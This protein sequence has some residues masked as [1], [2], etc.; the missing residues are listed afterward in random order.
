MIDTAAFR[1]AWALLDRRERRNAWV[2]LAV[3]AISA[4]SAALMVGSVFPFLRVLAEPSSITTVPQLNWAYEAFG[5]ESNFSFLI[6]LGLASLAVVILSNTLQLARV[7]VIARYSQM[8]IHTLS[9]KLLGLYLSQ[10]YEFFLE[11]H[12]GDM[13]TRVLSEAQETVNSFFRPFAEVT[14]AALTVLAVVTLLIWVNPAVAIGAFL[15]FGGFYGGL[16]AIVRNTLTNLGKR[17]AQANQQRFL[18]AKEVLGGIKEVK[19]RGHED[20]YLR[21]FCASSFNAM[22]T[23]MISDLIGG[24]PRYVVQV[25]SLG[26]VILLCLLLLDRAEFEAGTPPLAEL[27]PLIGIIAFAGQRIVPELSRIYQNIAKMR[28]GAAA[29]D[30]LF[31]DFEAAA[32]RSSVTK[33]ASEA[34]GLRSEFQLQNVSY[35]YPDADRNSLSDASL[36]IRAGERIGIVG[37]TGAGKT[38]IADIILGLLTPSD[39]HV[40]VDG[41]II[42]DLNR[43]MWQQSV[44]YV[45]QEIF[46]IDATIAENI[47]FGVPAQHIDRERVENVAQIAQLDSFVQQELPAGYETKVG[48]RGVRLSGGQRQRI[49]IARALYHGADLIVFDEATSALDNLT[50]R[51]VMSAIE[52]VPG[53]KTILMIAH[54]L[55]TVKKCDRIVVLN[56]GRIVGVGPWSELLEQNPSFRELAD[57]A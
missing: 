39:G 4:L 12:S 8:R 42:D 48:E 41:V 28:F 13:T 30:S 10:P 24:L 16:F 32:S 19:L 25:L 40:L 37:G 57:A 11:R 49:G 36:T 5:F 54:R 52:A 20:T 18:T 27:L 44:G 55:S 51:D 45:P 50:E 22:R 53:N 35:R 7:Y 9:R 47:A 33:P 3:V 1:K 15:V 2:V 14:A 56:G 43:R 31:E 46:L 6:A 21:R 34:L 38:T 26:G 29:V 23:V 17:R